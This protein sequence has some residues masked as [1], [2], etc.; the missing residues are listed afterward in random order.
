[1]IELLFNLTF[2]R[3]N[4]QK[5]A[6]FKALILKRLYNKIKKNLQQSIN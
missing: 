5:V 1:M 4:P 2:W 3:V 6:P